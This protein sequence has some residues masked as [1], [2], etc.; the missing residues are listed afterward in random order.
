M[1]AGAAVDE[2]RAAARVDHDERLH[3]G[4]RIDDGQLHRA[5]SG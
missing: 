5:D 3:A 2:D 1:N 4:A